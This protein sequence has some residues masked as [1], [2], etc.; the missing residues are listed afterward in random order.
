MVPAVEEA[1]VTGAEVSECTLDAWSV[2][3]VLIVGPVVAAVGIRKFGSL[4][5][6]LGVWRMGGGQAGTDPKNMGDI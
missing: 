6:S 4:H 5:I 1:S 3:M 2:D